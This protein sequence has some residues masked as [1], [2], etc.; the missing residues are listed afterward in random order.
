MREELFGHLHAKSK[1]VGEIANVNPDQQR[2]F[3]YVAPHSG[4]INMDLEYNDTL[5]ECNF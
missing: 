4:V 2:S 1:E 5:K 3:G